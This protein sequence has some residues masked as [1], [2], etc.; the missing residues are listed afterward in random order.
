M[1]VILNFQDILLRNIASN[2]RRSLHDQINWD[3][4]MIGI[5][6]PRS[7]GKTTLL[8]QQ[9]FQLHLHQISIEIRPI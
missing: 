6:G 9:F 2:F 7:A 5:T 8:L 3:Q 4:R 1:E